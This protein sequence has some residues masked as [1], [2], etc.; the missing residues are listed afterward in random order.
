MEKTSKKKVKKLALSTQI[1]KVRGAVEA[2]QEL[3]DWRDYALAEIDADVVYHYLQ[4]TRKN[5]ERLEARGRA[6]RREKK[7]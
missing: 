3:M 1:W 7:R 2:L 5:L 6:R 4:D